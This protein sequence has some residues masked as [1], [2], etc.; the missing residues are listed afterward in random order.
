[1]FIVRMR[2]GR[3]FGGTPERRRGGGGSRLHGTDS[4]FIIFLSEMVTGE[5]WRF[6][7]RGRS[8]SEPQIDSNQFILRNR[9]FSSFQLLTMSSLTSNL[10]LVESF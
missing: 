10:L 6:L 5:I 8:A 1:M 9:S 4:L 3:S 7:V 2:N